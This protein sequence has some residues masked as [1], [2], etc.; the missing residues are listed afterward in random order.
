[1]DLVKGILIDKILIIIQLHLDLMIV[2]REVI[3]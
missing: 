1:M 3:E 2:I